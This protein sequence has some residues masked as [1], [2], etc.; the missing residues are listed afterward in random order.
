MLACLRL[1]GPYSYALLILGES[2]S[3]KGE[4]VHEKSVQDPFTSTCQFSSA[5]Y[6]HL[7]QLSIV[8]HSALV[9]AADR[10]LI[11]RRSFLF[12]TA[13]E[14]YEERPQEINDRG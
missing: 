4:V 2:D 5:E 11:E 6:C 3:P 9:S 14:E 1:L 13:G 8:T 10:G 12:L 7:W